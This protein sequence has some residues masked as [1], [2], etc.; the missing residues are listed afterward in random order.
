VNLRTVAATNQDDSV[1]RKEFR[2][3]FTRT[4]TLPPVRERPEDIALLLRHLF[5]EAMEANPSLSRYVTTTRDGDLY[6]RFHPALVD[7][8]VGHPLPL[9]VRQL[10]AMLLEAIDGSAGETRVML[11]PN[12]ATSASAMW[13]MTAPGVMAEPESAL[14]PSS[15]G[16]A[17]SASGPASGGGPASAPPSSAAKSRPKKTK[18][19]IEAVLAASGASVRGAALALGVPRSTLQ[20]WMKEYGMGDDEG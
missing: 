9:N 5:L 10:R 17:R 1:F 13:G 18:G 7:F 8:L 16:G 6:P 15:G 4:L 2:A 20:R 12:F 14:A 11:P 19:E 3:R